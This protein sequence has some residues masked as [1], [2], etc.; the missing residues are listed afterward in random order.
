MQI[1]PYT[2]SQRKNKRKQPQYGSFYTDTLEVLH[3][4]FKSGKK[5]DIIKSYLTKQFKTAVACQYVKS[6]FAND[7]SRQYHTDNMRNTQ[8]LQ[9]NG[10]EQYND[11]HQKEN[12]R[13]VGDRKMKIKVYKIEHFF[14]K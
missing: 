14:H 8:P 10:G 6:M 3:V 12:P 13:R 7:N 2:Y 9:H 11:Q 5:H 1:G 4:H